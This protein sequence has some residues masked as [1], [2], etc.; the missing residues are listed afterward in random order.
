MI[1]FRAHFSANF[2]SNWSSN[3]T[4]KYWLQLFCIFISRMHY[5]LFLSRSLLLLVCLFSSFNMWMMPNG[6]QNVGGFSLLNDLFLFGWIVCNLIHS[7]SEKLEH[8][9]NCKKKKRSARDKSNN[10][11]DPIV[12]P[13]CT[14]THA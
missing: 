11:K 6:D 4:Q 10:K 8:Y 1:E 7:T 2:I 13:M 5:N 12:I 3:Y 14:N 9:E